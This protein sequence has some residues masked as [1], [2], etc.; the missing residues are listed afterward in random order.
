MR[1]AVHDWEMGIEF[2]PEPVQELTTGDRSRRRCSHPM[3]RDRNATAD[4]RILPNGVRTP[5][6]KHPA[7]HGPEV[8]QQSLPLQRTPS[9]ESS[10]IR[11]AAW[12][13]R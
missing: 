5:I 1:E 6:S 2:S 4:G 13:I 11:V 8:L 7:T 10:V 12:M 9:S 3:T